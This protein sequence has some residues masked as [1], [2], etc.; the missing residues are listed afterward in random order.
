MS[1][2]RTR[3]AQIRRSRARRKEIG[4]LIA[5]GRVARLHPL[6]EGGAAAR[7]VAEDVVADFIQTYGTAAGSREEGSVLLGHPLGLLEIPAAAEEY[8]ARVGPKTRNM[9]RRA[10]RDGYEFGPFAWNDHLDDIYEINTSSARRSGGEMRGWY[11]EPV[12]PREESELREYYGAFKDGRLYGYLHLVV[13]GDFG[14]FRHF[15]GHA[16]ELP[17]GIM[18][19]LISWTIERYAGSALKWLKYGA[20]SAGDD[21]MTAFKR[22]AGFTPYATFLELRG[23]E[24]DPVG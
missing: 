3:L 15:L 24:H 10:A 18:N 14:F 20:L 5:A 22:H 4:N 19:G 13:C 7:E 9:I 23:L 6:L 12:E 17:S 1:A 16:D 2:L 21:S 8:L 11:T